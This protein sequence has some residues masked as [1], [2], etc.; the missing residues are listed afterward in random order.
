MP[1][2]VVLTPAQTQWI[3]KI[4]HETL[5]GLGYREGVNLRVDVVSADGKLDRLRKLADDAV[6]TAPNVI[7]AVNTPGTQAAADA[8]STIPIV[9]AAVGDPVLLGFVKSIAR[10]ERNITG[11]ANMA[12]DITSKRIALLKEV[13][14]SVRR[15]AVFLHPDE[16]IVAPQMKDIEA[17]AGKLGIEYRTFPMRSTDDL[18]RSMRQAVEWKADAVL[19]LAGQGFA[20]GADTGRLAT[21]RRLPSMLMSKRDVEA[22]G[23]MSYFADHRDLFARIA[24]QVD[25]I[26]KSAAPRDLPFELPTRFELIVNTR[27]AKTLG[28]EVTSSV[29]ARADEVIE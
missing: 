14:P 24:M 4:F 13:A 9:S 22:G 26:L 1:R 7:V 20:L 17:S 15:V 27:T 23:L 5:A 12:G 16:P 28:L 21:E 6:R 25:R 11:V 19:R 2:V 10:P 3:P 29:L 18:L 8:T